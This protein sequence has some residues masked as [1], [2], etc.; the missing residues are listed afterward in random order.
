MEQKTESY[1]RQ[2]AAYSRQRGVFLVVGSIAL[3]LIGV[4]NA[5]AIFSD[6]I[7]ADT[8]WD[9]QYM[10][11]TFM[12]SIIGMCV[13]CLL[14]SVVQTKCKGEPRVP[15]VLG[16]VFMCVGMIATALNSSMGPMGVF[17]FYGA[18]GGIGEGLAF[19]AIITTVNLWFPDR[20]GLASGIQMFAYTSA[21]LFLGIPLDSAMTAFGWRATFVGL[22]V[23]Y[24]VILLAAA[25]VSKM[26]P[27][28]LGEFFQEPAKAADGIAAGAQAKKNPHYLTDFG[29]SATSFTAPQAMKTKTFWI[30]LAWFITVAAVSLTLIGESKQDAL[31]LGVDAGTATLLAG[32]VAVGEGG[33]SVVYGFYLDRFGL[34]SM[35]R[36]ISCICVLACALITAAF[37]TGQ[38]MVFFAGAIVLTCAYGGLPI[39]S[40]TFA[41]KRFGKD[42]Y[43]M[44]YAIA[45]TWLSVGSVL[46]MIINPA[47]LAAGGLLFMYGFFTLLAAA[48]LVLML[49]F[50]RMYRKDMAKLV[51]A[52]EAQE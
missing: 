30:G 43:S 32:L 3:L 47:L 45:T 46:N 12:I 49:V 29:V 6:P 38:G 40:A 8:G 27:Y 16:A 18:L 41:L 22:G 2:R 48:G 51:L 28:N 17:L 1:Q 11:N 33:A 21:P 19:N 7:C 42:Y 20:V 35:V 10:T 26:P 9:S 25:A 23:A 50:V 13:G 31:S 14:S 39:F 44:N 37:V 15:V 4:I 34:M 52:D 5:W 36:L 24:I